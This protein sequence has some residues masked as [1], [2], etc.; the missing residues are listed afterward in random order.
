MKKF[1]TA[2][3]LK[4]LMGERN[5]RQVDILE[6][7]KP[8]CEQYK[9]R[10]GRNDLSQYVAGKNEPGQEKLTILAKALHVSEAWLMGFEVPL[11]NVNNTIKELNM[12]DDDN[13]SL[14]LYDLGHDISSLLKETLNMLN[15]SQLKLMFDGNLIDDNTRE[16]LK[17]SIENS[18][19]I[20]T[21]NTANQ[22]KQIL[23]AAH[24]NN[25]TDQEEIEKMNQDLDDLND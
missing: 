15:N 5:L 22:Q 4:Q 14:I 12:R 25:K 2:D 18:L 11:Q 9:V 17:A 21:I 6:K 20:A 19:K 1:T 16:L 13:E 7:C 8:F 23:K 24:N 10:L 3:R